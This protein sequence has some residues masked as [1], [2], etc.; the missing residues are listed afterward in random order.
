MLATFSHFIITH[1]VNSKI[2]NIS[3]IRVDN[4]RSTIRVD[5]KGS[6]IRVDD[7]KELTINS[8]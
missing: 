4:N 1:L 7:N 5:Q 2:S 6:T 3:T 8:P